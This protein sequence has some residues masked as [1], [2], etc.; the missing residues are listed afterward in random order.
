[1]TRYIQRKD[2]EGWAQKA[3]EVFRIACCDCGLVH[4]LVVTNGRGPS[5]TCMS[6]LSFRPGRF[7]WNPWE[8]D[9]AR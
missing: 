2:G 6:D 7:V 3:G 1:M 4:D 9:D 5:Q 8:A